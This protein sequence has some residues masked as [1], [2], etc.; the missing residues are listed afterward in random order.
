M[1]DNE[2]IICPACRHELPR[3]AFGTRVNGYRRNCCKACDNRQRITRRKRKAW[4]RTL[5]RLVL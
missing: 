5:R 4:G 1:T 2:P 3:A